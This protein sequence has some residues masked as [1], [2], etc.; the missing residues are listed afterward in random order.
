QEAAQ[1]REKEATKPTEKERENEAEQFAKLESKWP[2][3]GATLHP[4]VSKMPASV[5]TS[6]ESV[7][8]Y[9]AK[10]ETD[11]TLRIKA[12]HDYVADRVAYD[13]EALY[14]GNFP[15]QGAQSVFKTRKSV[16]AGYANLL[17]A[18]AAAIGENIVVVT[19]YARDEA[20]GD[21]LTGI[22]HA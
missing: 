17:S 16:C 21:K 14:S 20:T 8:R 10:H 5:E 6:I 22:G 18:L 11:P 3:K 19:G 15:D 4:A 12:L 7:A 9:I 1:Q 2:W 13:S